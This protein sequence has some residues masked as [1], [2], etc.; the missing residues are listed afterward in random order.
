MIEEVVMRI[1]VYGTGGAGG[2]LVVVWPRLERM[3]Y[4]SPEEII[5][6]L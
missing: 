4:S 3:W 2:I 5:C 1:A 6:R